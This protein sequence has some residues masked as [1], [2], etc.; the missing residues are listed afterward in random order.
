MSNTED[1]AQI[2]HYL[3]DHIWEYH[4]PGGR[5]DMERMAQAVSAHFGTDPADLAALRDLA[6]QV[7]AGHCPQCGAAV[8]GEGR[9]CFC[10]GWAPGA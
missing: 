7:A 6:A 8:Q 3:H 9:E 10:C 2:T 5:Y 1:A 4:L